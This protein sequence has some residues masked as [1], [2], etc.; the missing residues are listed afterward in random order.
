[1]TDWTESEVA[2]L[3]G[4]LEGEGCFLWR[5]IGSHHYPQIQVC[6]T[7]HDI[8]ERVA[9]M[10]GNSVTIAKRPKVANHKQ[11]WCTALHGQKAADWMAVVLPWLGERRAAKVKE[12]L[13][14]QAVRPNYN[15]LNALAKPRLGSR[16]I[17]QA[18]RDAITDWLNAEQTYL[19]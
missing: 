5:R 17:S 19:W 7:D 2:W 13:A 15:R 16:F 8:V 9:K 12:I 1:M 3:A 4:L 6:M 11:M 14:N 10:L 18:E